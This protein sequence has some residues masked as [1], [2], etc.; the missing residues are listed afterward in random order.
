[1]IVPT[2][3]GD[4][5]AAELG[6][7][8]VHEH[9][10]MRDPL[11]E[12]EELDDEQ[13]S[14]AELALLLRSGFDAVLEL[15]PLGLG[16]DPGGLAAMAERT[17]AHVVMATGVHHEGHYAAGHPLRA[18]SAEQLAA[19][20][21]ADLLDGADG[22]G[23]RAG[24]IKVGAG[25]WSISP[26][27]RSALEAAAASHA[28][29][30]AP[31]VCHLEQGTAAVELLEL[32]TRAGVP[33]ARVLLAHIDRNP[34]P[35][36]HAELAAA[37]AYLGYDGWSRA[38]Y[39]PDSVLIDCLLRSAERGAA[40][41]IVLGNDLARRSAFASYGGLPGMSYLG[42][43]V[44]PRLRTLGGE[45]LV[46]TVLVDNPARLLARPLTRSARD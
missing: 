44:L 25:Y 9:L 14:A 22:T 8:N 23:V 3:L 46:D 35:G 1:M 40:E 43:R 20:F 39:W 11:L 24:V 15:T 41:R 28:R 32:L 34:D 13:R 10:M 2:V 7:T 21:T 17:G 12:G 27:E 26:F 19:R 38:K 6:R 31:V 30:G 18:L 33:A 37:G 36:L 45:E 42:E 5:P 16:R 4:V 29:T